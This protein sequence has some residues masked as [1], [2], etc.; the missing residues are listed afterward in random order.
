MDTVGGD[1]FLLGEPESLGDGLAN[2]GEGVGGSGFE[3]TLCDGGEELA[4]GGGEVTSGDEVVR[5]SGGEPAAHFLGGQGLG[6]REGVG[7][8]EICVRWA[9]EHAAMAAVGIGEAADAG[10]ALESRRHVG[11]LDVKA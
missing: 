10:V 5:E 11:L 7:D 6:F 4:Q 3:V 2:V 1:E 8:T 9:D